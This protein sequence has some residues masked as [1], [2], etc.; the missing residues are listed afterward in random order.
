[1]AKPA[2]VHLHVHSEYSLLDGAC[3][4]QRKTKE[5]MT[6]PLAERAAELGM[7]A[8]ALTDHG[9]MNGAV[10]HYKACRQHGIK[11]I[12]GLEA[13]MVDDRRA[14]RESVRYERNHLTLL[15]ADDTGF[16][17]LVQLSSA[18]F[19]EGFARGRA[20]LDMELLER[21]SQGV[22]ALTGCLQSRPCRQRA[23]SS[24]AVPTP[25]R[26]ALSSTY[27]RRPSASTPTQRPPPRPRRLLRKSTRSRSH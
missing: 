18:S 12:I 4:I 19:L 10:D 7:P 9:V 2:A 1:M 24:P 11:P 6:H 14:A 8:L 23:V 15:A 22:I 27:S 16:R 17:N 25:H 26:P 20:N 21:H 3:K 13:Y 5:R